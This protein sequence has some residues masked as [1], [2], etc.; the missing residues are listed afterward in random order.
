MPLTQ[1]RFS[2]LLGV[3]LAA[4]PGIA[5]AQANTCRWAN[6]GECDEARYGGTGACETGTDANDCRAEAAAWQRLMNAVPAD[7]RVQLGDDSCRWANDLECDDIRFGGTGACAAGTD[8]SDCRALAVGGDDSCRWAN[9]GECDEPGIGTGLC[10]SGTD[11][12]DC[13]AV[14]VMRNRTNT[15]ETAFNGI[16]EEPGS[17][18]GTCASYTD[19]ADCIGRERPIQ[20]RDHFFGRDERVRPDVTR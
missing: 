20:L 18:S 15:C 12:T 14:A 16:C 3:V 9:D 17:G 7:I 19:T 13:A 10:T 1:I 2:L 5:S 6:D 4:L 8:A 11:V